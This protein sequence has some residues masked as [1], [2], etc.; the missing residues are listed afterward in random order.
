MV[1][2]RKAKKYIGCFTSSDRLT[3]RVVITRL[4][5]LRLF[6]RPVMSLFVFTLLVS[7]SVP[8]NS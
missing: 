7:R 1:K 2:T 8:R 3:L 4:V 5:W 6:S